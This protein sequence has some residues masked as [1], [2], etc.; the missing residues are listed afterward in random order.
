M[1]NI[2]K[3]FTQPI[4]FNPW[5]NVYGIARSLLASSTLL[6][7]IFNDSEI[8]FAP[9]FG[10]QPPICLGFSRISLF[11]I[12]TVEIELVRMVMIIVLLIIVSGWRPRIT[13]IFH[14][15]IT[16]SISS[17][18]LII[19]GGDQVASVITLLLIPICL[20]DG[21]VWHWDNSC[22]KNFGISFTQDFRFWIANLF[23]F[24]IRLQVALIYFFAGIEKLKVEEWL[25]G[26]AVY[27]WFMDPY[28]GSSG[29]LK[30]LLTQILKFDFVSIAFTWGT[31]VLEIT[32]FLGLV[33]NSDQ[34]RC[35]L[36]I[37][38]IFH[39]L[40]SIIHGLIPFF[41]SMSAALILYLYPLDMSFHFKKAINFQIER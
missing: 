32:L 12:A 33:M 28:M 7:L 40:I 29:F 18:S 2:Y 38:L 11:C 34:R 17:T 21:R 22:E 9:S 14:W 27:Y 30:N 4:T 36:Y 23:V 8:L 25:N 13:G 35:L 20:T 3:F 41:F 37:G 24:L 26:T 15:Y 31:L 6:T 10:I 5:T 16:F 19:D 1:L 39:F